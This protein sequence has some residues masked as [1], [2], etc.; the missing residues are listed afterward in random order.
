MDPRFKVA[1]A[2][3]ILFRN[4]LDSLLG[5]HFSLRAD[6]GESYW[7]TPMQYFDETLPRD[8]SRLSLDGRFVEGDNH[9]E[10]SPGIGFHASIFRARPDVNCII[11]THA[12][13]LAVLSTT[14]VPLTPYHDHAALFLDDVAYYRDEPDKDTLAWPDEIATALADK[15]VLLLRNHGSINV[16][17]SIE[18]AT[19]DAVYLEWAARHQ[20][21]SMAVGG[22]AM[23][24]AAARWYQEAYRKRGAAELTWEANLRRLRRSDP[25]L[26]EAAG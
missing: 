8:V 14:D 6:D 18:Q 11:H 20:L 19:G 26:F 3:R 16:A 10:P 5:G 24:A 9:L 7:I 2:R 13:H 17:T 23:P 4:G 21:A 12:F 15:T 22:E 25:D 1:A